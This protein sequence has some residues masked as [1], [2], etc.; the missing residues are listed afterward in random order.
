MN[1]SIRNL[2][3]HVKVALAPALALLGLVVVAA[4]AWFG[5]RHLA[6]ELERVSGDALQ[7]VLQAQSLGSDT[8]RVHQRIYQSLT[9]EAVGQRAESIAELDKSLNG[10]I[11]ALN[12]QVAAAVAA[13]ESPEDREN[14]QALA[15]AVGAYAKIA[16][17][18]LDIKTAGVATAASYVVTLDQHF[19]GIQQ[20]VAAYVAERKAEAEAEVAAAKAAAQ[21]QNLASAT[22][23]LLLLGGCTVLSVW[24]ARLIT[25]PLVD[26]AAVASRLAEGDL[27]VRQHDVAADATGRVQAALDTVAR[28]L[29][30]VV[31]EIRGAA[32]Q[33]DS[34][35]SEI[36][37]GNRDLSARTESAASALQQAAASLEELTTTVRQSA[38]SARD[39]SVLAGQASGIAREGGT[40][41]DEVVGTMDAINSQAK[42]IADIIGTIDGIAFQTNILAL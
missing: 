16:V 42:R 17:D 35:S 36:A 38:D 11:Q 22:I 14:K 13:S 21:R 7:R 10:E 29:T 41:V 31:G 23:A 18:T 25:R 15:D 3:I 19:A 1:W 2:P 37:S 34:A 26:A 24:V 4:M 20:R 28:N 12:A 33:I 8:T 27:T 6:L 39:A 32:G 30:A 40:M 5:N 9:W